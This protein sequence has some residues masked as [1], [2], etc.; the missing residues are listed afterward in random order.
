MLVSFQFA[1]MYLLP[2]SFVEYSKSILYSLG[3]TSNFFFHYSGREYGAPS[4]LYI[5]FLHTWSLSIEEQFYI[6][7]PITLLIVCKY[8]RKYLIHILF[9]VFFISLGF[10]EWTSRNYSSTSFYFLHTRIW[11]LLAGS[12]LAFFEI[13]RG[14]RSRSEALNKTLP[15]VGLTLIFFSVLFYSDEIVHPSIYTL[16]PIIGVCI[17]IWFSTK[18]EV[19][20]KIL[21]TKLFVGIGLISYSLY[22]WHYPVFAFVRITE[23]TLGN[24]IVK[25]LI[26]PIIF[27]LSIASYYFIEKPFEIK[28]ITF[29]NY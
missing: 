6:I 24:V 5:P 16:L 3:F 28:K 9:C 7:F 29:R 2:N 12:I 11:E 22:L 23:L 17:I 20:T 26:I 15:V 4:A 27:I 21:S 19:I 14:H 1:W 13:T 25:I 8:F 18:D 10:A